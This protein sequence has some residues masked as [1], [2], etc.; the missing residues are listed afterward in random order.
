MSFATL[1]CG[2]VLLPRFLHVAAS[3]SG[4]PVLVA[5]AL[6]PPPADGSPGSI[7]R[8]SWFSAWMGSMLAWRMIELLGGFRSRMTAKRVAA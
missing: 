6:P 3:H 1:A 7:I 2:F 8:P 5:P 4:Q